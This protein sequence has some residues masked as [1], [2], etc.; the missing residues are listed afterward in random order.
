MNR[1]FVYILSLIFTFALCVDAQSRFVVPE[2]TF[3]D[4]DTI[5]IYLDESVTIT[6]YL[7]KD[8][9]NPDGWQ[10]ELSGNGFDYATKA[11]AYGSFSF[12]PP[13]YGEYD[14]VF[15]VRVYD[16]NVRYLNLADDK[17]EVILDTTK[18]FV[19]RAFS[20]PSMN[21]IA[22]TCDRLTDVAGQMV[23]SLS[24]N[25]G[26]TKLPVLTTYSEHYLKVSMTDIVGLT[27]YWTFWVND[28]KVNA[29]EDYFYL[30]SQEECHE[31]GMRHMYKV[32][33][34][35]KLPYR[36][37][38][39]EEEYEFA[40]DVYPN[41]VVS[42][43][44]YVETYSG[45]T[46]GFNFSYSGGVKD[47]WT[48]SWTDLEGNRYT[49]DEMNN[50]TFNVD[51]PTQYQYR[52]YLKTGNDK[53]GYYYGI[54]Y[55][56]LVVWEKPHATFSCPE[57]ATDVSTGTVKEY[58]VS[59]VEGHTV[60]ISFSVSGGYLSMNS[61]IC[62][63]DTFAGGIVDGVATCNYVA[64]VP[65]SLSFDEYGICRY[66]VYAY[67]KNLYTGWG[68]T[69]DSVWYCDSV[70]LNMKVV[71]DILPPVKVVKKGN[72]K[73]GTVIAM[74]DK[75]DR[76]A[77]T[78]GYSLVFGYEDVKAGTSSTVEREYNGYDSYRAFKLPYFT[79][80]NPE[81]RVFVYARYI[82]QEGKVLESER[83]YLDSDDSDT[84]DVT[85]STLTIDGRQVDEPKNGLFV[86]RMSD[87]SV[88]KQY[89]RY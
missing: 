13:V 49:P 60:P 70:R 8:T 7:N 73:S 12:T 72:G 27:D 64:N 52:L 17:S 2:Y 42:L 19:V 82:N 53:I 3:Q 21:M 14:D 43:S 66:S 6:N 22:M 55:P 45:M 24:K 36:K 18:T 47:L 25:A 57:S 68:A 16:F 31:D 59:C 54:S 10:V 46:A 1:P 86:V 56:V 20:K 33:V 15:P 81:Y 29:D 65:D 75:E 28:I 34:R 62:E 83:C 58:D 74:L 63:V 35:N 69:P 23:Y 85:R 61:W 26:G 79:L 71:R 5:D 48:I 50:L 77:N 51:K 38:A 89:I 11:D 78:Y 44:D 32:K 88:K 76:Y 4:E 87:G 80:H 84:D 41:P 30:Y 67:V 37:D 9:G 40:C 39:Y